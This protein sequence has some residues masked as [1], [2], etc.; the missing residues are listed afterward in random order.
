MDQQLT[1]KVQVWLNT[2]ADKRDLMK[3]AQYLLQLSGNPIMYRN[4][5]NNINR[6]AADIEY[7]LK[8]YVNF[9][10]QS[11]THSQ[12]AEM[13]AQVAAIIKRNHLD[14]P[15]NTPQQKRAATL[16]FKKGKRSDHDSLPKEIQA[17]Y[18]NNLELLQKMR[19]LHTKLQLLS[20]QSNA[21]PDSERYPFLKVLIKLDKEYHKNWETYDKFG[22]SK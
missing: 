1:Q 14:V 18:T 8:K 17:C 15:L 3:G 21:C 13:E 11:L 4:I 19:S 20:T 10:L 7:Q 9:R 6:H 5:C 2:P 16:E 22:K 12:V